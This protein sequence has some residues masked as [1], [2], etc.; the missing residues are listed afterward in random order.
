MLYYYWN[1]HFSCTGPTCQE[2][3]EFNCG[4]HCIPMSLVCNN[5]NDCG[6]NEDEPTDGSCNRNECLELNGDCTHTCV[7][8]PA[9]YYCKCNSGYMLVNKTQCEGKLLSLQII[10][11]WNSSVISEILKHCTKKG[12]LHYWFL[13][14][15]SRAYLD[16]LA[17]TDINECLEPGIC[18]QVCVN[19]KGE[20]KCECVG[21]YARDPNNHRRCKA[22][23]G[24]ASL[25]FAHFSDIRKI[26]LDHQEVKLRLKLDHDSIS[27]L[28]SLAI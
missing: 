8:T 21:G 23:E 1:F 24:H 5:I 28:L 10:D 27:T 25:L 9:S 6:N 12:D 13:L 20:F 18:S 11:S 26:S 17:L 7:D 4:T 19:S 14:S 16:W 15:Y 2:D 3:I 22:M